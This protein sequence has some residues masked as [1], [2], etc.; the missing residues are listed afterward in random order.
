MHCRRVPVNFGIFGHFP[1][2]RPMPAKP[3]NAHRIFIFVI[4]GISRSP[5]AG[6]HPFGTEGA[7]ID[8]TPF[9]ACAVPSSMA[10][11]PIR[12]G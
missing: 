8:C 7:G 6:R 9:E 4:F 5:P 10:V 12:S 3:L 2:G 1:A 11:E